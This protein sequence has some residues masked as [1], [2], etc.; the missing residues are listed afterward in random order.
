MQGACR[1]RSVRSARHRCGVR[2]AYAHARTDGAAV[3]HCYG[4]AYANAGTHVYSYPHADGHAYSAT[5]GDANR[6]AVSHRDP[7]APA[8]GD[9]ASHCNASPHRDAYSGRNAD[10]NADSGDAHAYASPSRV[11]RRAGL[12]RRGRIGG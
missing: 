12:R 1:R 3:A 4:D 7:D 11:H 5:D 6:N 8:N 9:A 2:L 10:P